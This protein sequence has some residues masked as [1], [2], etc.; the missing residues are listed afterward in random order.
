MPAHFKTA[1]QVA[2]FK[3]AQREFDQV[4]L[5]LGLASPQAIQQRN[6]VVP[7]RRIIRLIDFDQAHAAAAV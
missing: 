6:S 2:R 1:A 7:S 5:D 4:L 3:R